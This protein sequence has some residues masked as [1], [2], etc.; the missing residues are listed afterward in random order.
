MGSKYSK[1]NMHIGNIIQYTRR[2]KGYTLESM[3]DILP[4]ELMKCLKM[5][6]GNT[7]TSDFFIATLDWAKRELE[8]CNAAEAE[9]M[10]QIAAKAMRAQAFKGTEPDELELMQIAVMDAIIDLNDAA[11]FA[12]FEELLNDIEKPNASD[13]SDAHASEAAATIFADALSAAYWNPILG[14]VDALIEVVGK[15]KEQEYQEALRAWSR[16]VEEA[17]TD[18]LN[19][20]RE[21]KRA[22]ALH[23][24]LK[25]E[26]QKIE[27]ELKKAK[28]DDE[29]KRQDEALL[30]E[31]KQAEI[32]LTKAE[33]ALAEDCEKKEAYE[34]RLS[35]QRKELA[36]LGMFA[37]DKKKTL[38]YEIGNLESKAKEIGDS[39]ESR[40]GVIRSLKK[41]AEQRRNLE[42]R[43][44]AYPESRVHELETKVRNAKFEANRAQKQVRETKEAK[45]ESERLL[46]MRR[47]ERPKESSYSPEAAKK[48]LR[49]RPVISEVLETTPASRTS[50]GIKPK[51]VSGYRKG[52]GSTW[53][54][55]RPT[56]FDSNP[57]HINGRTSSG[58]SGSR[59]TASVGYNIKVDDPDMTHRMDIDIEGP[60][61]A[62]NTANV[63]LAEAADAFRRRSFVG[64]FDFMRDFKCSRLP[65][66]SIDTRLYVPKIDM[67]ELGAAIGLIGAFNKECPQ[68]R[69][70]GIIEMVKS[71]AGMR[72]TYHV[73]SDAGDSA[74]TAIQKVERLR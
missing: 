28:S 40:E 72:N 27:E 59:Y 7:V 51:Q 70:D 50:N 26:Q 14:L 32:D 64:K 74:I 47:N 53:R 54:D 61:D 45:L 11:E 16:N 60:S 1:S 68:L 66:T 36:G 2:G 10:S 20:E 39:I 42:R 33:L 46:R 37:F 43:L 63:F 38:R 15:K 3:R 29:L 35:Q 69:I 22:E 67:D 34:L 6:L 62:F 55:R 56:F 17:E 13:L 24:G 65:F 9:A 71:Y 25:D 48:P 73:T 30:A 12:S 49:W 4:D 58:F 44:T 8:G 31:V 41:K 18:L 5:C 19:A 57:V 23:S 21:V 52:S